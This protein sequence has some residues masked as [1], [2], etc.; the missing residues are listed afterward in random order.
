MASV[1]IQQ[2]I[3]AG[4]AKAV[5]KTGSS[6]S[7][8][9]Y[10]VSKIR[11]GGDGTPLN[12][13]TVTTSEVLLKDAIFKSY[14]KSLV[15]GNIEQGDRELVSGSDVAITT[16]STVKAGSDSYKVISVEIKAPAGDAL[17]Y[18][19]QLRLGA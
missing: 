13:G 6:S 15:G 1:D 18:M 12:P 14:D 9:V 4:L 19:S 17:V 10:L 8:K 3:K 7:D 5:N 11:T 16:G 2:R